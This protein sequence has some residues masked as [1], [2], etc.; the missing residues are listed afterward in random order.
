[1]QHSGLTAIS[2]EAVSHAVAIVLQFVAT[3][4]PDHCY[5]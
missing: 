5:S 2:T 3:I 1:M 4:C